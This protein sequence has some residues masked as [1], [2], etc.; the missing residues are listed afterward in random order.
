MHCTKPDFII[1]S[2]AG[3]LDYL[4]GLAFV[5]AV[6]FILAMR[7][8]K[9]TKLLQVQ[10]AL[11]AKVQT[12]NKALLHL[13]VDLSNNNV[14]RDHASEKQRR[15]IYLLNKRVWDGWTIQ[16]DEYVNL[17]RDGML[18]L[19][20][21]KLERPLTGCSRCYL[22]TSDIA[23]A[24]IVRRRSFRLATQICIPSLTPST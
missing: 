11:V 6:C 14:V 23:L 4:F 10:T 15:E 8:Q 22:D 2:W 17:F 18:L 1:G 3:T 5:L 21:L 20:L 9:A 24:M 16:E 12:E 13:L 7:L 19:T